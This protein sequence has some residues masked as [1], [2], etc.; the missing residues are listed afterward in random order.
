VAQNT[1]LKPSLISEAF[2]IYILRQSY[3][4]YITNYQL[5]IMSSLVHVALRQSAIFIPSDQQNTI[6]KN[7]SIT[8][9]TALLAANLATLGYGLSEPLLHA[10]NS[11]TEAFQTQLLDS[12]RAIMGVNKNWTPL[13]KAWDTPTGESYIDHILTFYANQF[14]KLSG[15]R[16]ACGHLIPDN[17]FPIARYTGCPFC[18]TPFEINTFET[19]TLELKTQGTKQKLLTLWTDKEVAKFFKDLLQSKT[20]LDATQLDSLNI[21]LQYLPIPDARIEMKET[22][23]AVANACIDLGLG[24]K[25]ASLFKSPADI[26][27]FL[28]AKH[29]GFMQIVQPK[30]IARRKSGNSKNRHKKLDKNIA[31]K[32]EAIEKLKLKYSRSFSKVVAAWLNALPMP[33]DKAAEIMHPRRQMWVRFIR[34]LRLSEYAKRDGFAALARLLHVFYTEEYTVWQGQVDTFRNKKDALNALNLLSQRAGAFSRALFANMLCFGAAPVCSAF[35]GIID[36]VPA[37]LLFTLNATAE[38]YFDPKGI[39]RTVKPLGGTNKVISQNKKL[40]NYTQPQLDEMISQIEA[41][42]ILAVQKRFEAQENSNKTIFI[43]P[44]LNKIPVSIGDRSS[45]VQDLPSALMG[46]RFDVQGDTVRLFMQWGEGLP[47][48]HMDMD[49]SCR[50]AYADKLEIC[51]FGNLVT[52]GCKHSGDIRAIPD[53]VGTAEY[54]D[55]NLPELEAAG[56][57][58]LTFTCNAYSNGSITPNLVLGWMDSQKPMSIDSQTGIAYDPSCVQ[59]QVRITQSLA[60]GLVFGVLEVATRQII[61]LEVEFSGQITLNLDTR[62]VEM[63]LKKLDAKLNI[64]ALLQLKAKAQGL[65][66]VDTAEAADEAYTAEWARNVAA[67]T[68][69]LVD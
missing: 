28:W 6:V 60:K 68:Q 7:S 59:H 2:I 13:V 21:L 62:T 36:K 11:T 61:W 17:T 9:A 8:A 31:A 51:Y 69:L 27:R 3:N 49:L 39:G 58:Y 45:N 66:F 40:K 22:V 64:G 57:I 42:C 50:I 53:K 4:Y 55:I 43:D 19:N 30:I 67:V 14:D 5:F 52:V 46:T 65:M 24:E 20:A 44:A 37:R 63:L 47:A 35:A 25:A 54:I 32:A 56:A 1:S 18:G 15:T 10:L 41:L 38:L 33:A 34:A 16:L 12:F 26:L 23:V 48:Q 29:T